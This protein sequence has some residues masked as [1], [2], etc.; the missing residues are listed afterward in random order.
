MAKAPSATLR[1]LVDLFGSM[2]FAISSLSIL[3]V[4]SV[5]GT[6][7]RQREP[8]PNYVNQFGPFW[9]E[10][11]RALGLYEV[12]NAWWFLLVL[13]FLVASTSLCLVR[14]TPK[15]LRD[16][17]AWREQVR[18]GSLR[19][20]RH[21]GELPLPGDAGGA[22]RATAEALTRLGYRMK[23]DARPEGTM[24]AAKRGATNRLGYVFAHAGIVVVCLGGLLDSELPMRAMVSWLD[25][26]A[27]PSS[28]GV[29]T[30]VPASAVMPIGNPS[31]RGNVFIPEGGTAEVALLPWGD[32]ALIQELPFRVEL[33]RFR[34]DYYATGMPKLFASEVDVVDR[35]TGRREQAVIKVNEPLIRDGIAI[36]QSSFDDGG[37]KLKMRAVPINGIGAGFDVETEVGGSVPLARADQPR[38]DGA[39]ALKLEITGFRPINVENLARAGAEGD[40]PERRF[41][42]SVAAVLS[43]AGDSRGKNLQNVG[44]S[45]QYKLRDPAGQAREFN[46]YQFPVEMD[47]GRVFL[48]GVRESPNE[49]FRY[50]RI[51]ADA[52]GTMAEWVRMRAALADPVRREAAALRYA[53]LAAPVRDGVRDPQADERLAGAARR[54]LDLFAEGGLQAVAEFIDA[55]VPAAEQPRAA[56]ALLKVLNGALW[57]LWQV[58]R[59]SAN[60]PP[61]EGN[62]ANGRFLVQAQAALSDAFLFGAPV[63]FELTDFTE[64]KASVLQMT[65]SP[66]KPIVYL[67]CLLLV[68]GT[69]AMFYVRERRVWCWVGRAGDDGP[70]LLYAMS[71]SRQTL[72]LDKEFGVLSEALATSVGRPHLQGAG[73]PV[74]SQEHR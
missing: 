40:L 19:A 14:N 18:V 74:P 70:R 60:L 8:F 16:M 2:R 52:D 43:P 72:D 9:A 10:Q 45:V 44:P 49:P 62:D 28:S 42:E 47:G 30:Q 7:L 71:S 35:R 69:F 58:S 38:A 66:G 1:N 33:K 64:I 59:E 53:R 50:L 29:M 41:K 11:L 6:L 65:R 17:R 13:A 24:I 67:G 51:P 22:A 12:Y 23:V 61:V 34:I 56:E 15:M 39:A 32:G 55:N 54:G 68:L 21:R 20:F 3:A 46:V 36:Y 26:A 27:L 25:K 73:G 4:A 63:V 48:A 57:E 37:S 5:I 31:W